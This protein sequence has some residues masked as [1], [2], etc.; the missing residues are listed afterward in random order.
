MSSAPRLEGNKVS[1]AEPPALGGLHLDI[2]EVEATSLFRVFVK[3]GGELRIDAAKARGAG[4]Y[5]DPRNPALYAV[6][7]SSDDVMTALA[8]VGAIREQP[9]GGRL[10][11]RNQFHEEGKVARYA[12]ARSLQI[13][14][15]TEDNLLK[16][17]AAD[18]V[19]ENSYF[20]CQELA[21]A[22]YKAFP[23]VD[24]LEYV[25]R[26]FPPHICWA[27]F[28]R[29]VRRTKLRATNVMRLQDDQS[30]TTALA[31]RRL[32]LLPRD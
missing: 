9:E 29:G 11:V 1:C 12:A 7:Y 18:T 14:S 21:L 16:L 2:K 8:E 15:L 22:I 20:K 26:K 31:T 6:T 13:L 27:L 4:R 17:K 24:G 5:D 10:I 28:D 3:T 30:Y 23:E 25:S 19:R 32:V